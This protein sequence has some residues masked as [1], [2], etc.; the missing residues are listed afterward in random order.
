MLVFR[1]LEQQTDMVHEYTMEQEQQIFLVQRKLAGPTLDVIQYDYAYWWP[2]NTWNE[3][4][5]ILLKHG[6]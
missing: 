4:N 2:V 6:Q 5:F 3:V 1:V